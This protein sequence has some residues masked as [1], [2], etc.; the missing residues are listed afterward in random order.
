MDRKKVYVVG[1]KAD[2]ELT[3]ISDSREERD[4]CKLALEKAYPSLSF[5]TGETGV[6][7]GMVHI[8][9]PTFPTGATD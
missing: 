4:M 1:T 7:L 8:D 9:K 2:T 3:F 5:Y 6:T